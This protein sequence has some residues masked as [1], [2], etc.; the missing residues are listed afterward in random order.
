MASYRG[1]IGGIERK[2]KDRQEITDKNITIAFQDL[3][4]LMAMVSSN[5]NYI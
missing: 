1:G 3:Q 5:L 2:I 4:K